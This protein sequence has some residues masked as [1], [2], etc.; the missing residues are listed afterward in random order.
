MR[1]GPRGPPSPLWYLVP[2]AVHGQQAE[3]VEG[4]AALGE[5]AHSHGP[6][7]PAVSDVTVPRG[8][9]QLLHTDDAVLQGGTQP[10]LP[11]C[12]HPGTA[13]PMLGHSEPAGVGAGPARS[14]EGVL[15]LQSQSSGCSRTGDHRAISPLPSSRAD[16]KTQATKRK[17]LNSPT[18]WFSLE[19]RAR[20][21]RVSLGKGHLVPSQSWPKRSQTVMSTPQA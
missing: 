18:Q 6:Q 20:E 14:E 7:S 9:R 15:G 10:C 17:E 11:P 21:E 4:M 16:Q 19:T 3:Q 8:H 2:V 13:T 5:A 1:T 12:R